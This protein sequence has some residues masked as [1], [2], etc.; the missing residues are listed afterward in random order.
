MT[1]TKLPPRHSDDLPIDA[2]FEPAP[3]RAESGNGGA[4]PGWPAFF[5][6][7]AVSV[8][9]LVLAVA[10]SGLL[11][12]SGRNLADIDALQAEITALQSE[13]DTA[14]TERASLIVKVGDLG[15]DIRALSARIQVVTQD[16]E[17]SNSAV[18]IL[19]GELKD[20]NES[21]DVAHRGIARAATVDPETGETVV[22]PVNPFILDRLET[23]EKALTTFAPNAGQAGENVASLSDEISALRAEIET[24]R[25][26]PSAAETTTGTNDATNT[27]DAA[28]ALSAIEAAAR[29]GRPFQSGYRRMLTAMPDEPTVRALA[30]LAATGA[31]TFS[32]LRDQFPALRRQALDAEASAAGGSTGWM[33]SVFGDGIIVRRAGEASAVTVLET[34]DAALARGDL[35]AAIAQIDTLSTNIQPVFTDW[36]DNARHRQSLE[37]AL[38]ALRLTMIAKDR[39]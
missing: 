35:S 30:P 29:R 19:E 31:P 36:L 21:L 6:L 26:H 39:P 22:A 15:P 18:A 3:K 4:G 14:R 2:E 34:A 10:T 33:R 27:A 12:G 20:L 16:I 25:N 1:D 17:A 23:L 37:D 9:S 5:L 28:L 11:P 7:A 24:L 38:E 32:D 8:A 13:R